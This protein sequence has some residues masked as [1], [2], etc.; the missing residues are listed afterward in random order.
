VAALARSL[1]RLLAVGGWAPLSLFLLHVALDAGLDAYAA[2]PRADVPMHLAGGAAM[3]FFVS[4]CLRVLTRESAN[5]R[6]VA[7]ELTLVVSLTMTAAVVWELGEFAL[8]RLADTRLQVSL[9]NTMQDLACGG[10]GA[11]AFVAAGVRRLR[12]AAA[13]LREIVT[14][15]SAATAARPTLEP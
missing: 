8:D 9:A 11:A 1:W 3:A 13:G 4:R 2:W 14:D 10:L 7:V 5:C 12:T 6:V 15:W